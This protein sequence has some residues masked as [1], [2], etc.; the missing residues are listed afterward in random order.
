MDI[1][2]HSTLTGIRLH[3][4]TRI[5]VDMQSKISFRVMLQG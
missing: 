5:V 3:D 1:E 2:H 4:S